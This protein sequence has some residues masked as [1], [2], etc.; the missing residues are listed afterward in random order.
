V[1]ALQVLAQGDDPE[2]A[3]LV[4]ELL[5][6]PAMRLAALRVLPRALR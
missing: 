3:A 6:D 4:K 1:Q 2:L 5:D